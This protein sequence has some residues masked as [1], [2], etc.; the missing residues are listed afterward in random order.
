MLTTFAGRSAAK[1]KS[2]PDSLLAVKLRTTKKPAFEGW[3]S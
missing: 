1:V 3:L 2:E